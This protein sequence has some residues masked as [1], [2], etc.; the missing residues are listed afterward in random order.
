IVRHGVVIPVGGV[1]PGGRRGWLD[2]LRLELRRVVAR[3][4]SGGVELVIKTAEGINL[5]GDA[6]FLIAGADDNGGFA[7]FFCRGLAAEIGTDKTLD[8]DWL[9]GPVDRPFAEHMTEGTWCLGAVN[10]WID[11]PG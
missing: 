5:D 10:L 9:L 6:P 3:C 8:V 11:G 7:L 1:L 2:A 4:R